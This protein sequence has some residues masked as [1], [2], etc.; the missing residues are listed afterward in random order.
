M[1]PA[2]H[3]SASVPIFMLL[4]VL[5]S[6]L[7]FD[8]FKQVAIIWLVVPLAIIGVTAGLLGT[9]QPFGFMAT[10]G[11][12][13]LIG[14][15]IKNAIVLVDQID[16]E[17]GEGKDGWNAILDSAISRFAPRVHGSGDHN[18]RHGAAVSGR[19][20]RLH[21]G[22]H[23][24]WAVVRHHTHYGGSCPCCTRQFDRVKAPSS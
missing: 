20:L 16:L 2:S 23:C 6:L 22:D 8:A 24:C 14:M 9:G 15:L 18:S 5:I 11:L 10:L 13:S 12:L 19:V 3:W 21:G 17:I 1:T 7:L 4:M